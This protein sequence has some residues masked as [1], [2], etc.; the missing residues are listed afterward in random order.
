HATKF[1]LT[2]TPIVRSIAVRE[3]DNCVMTSLQSLPSSIIFKMP[4]ICPCTRF[5]R[6]L[7]FVP[8]STTQRLPYTHLV[9]LLYTP[10]GKSVND[11]AKMTGTFS[12]ISGHLSS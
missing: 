5:K 3:A 10:C 11:C 12:I 9:H 2:I 6:F 4:L 7:T 8:Y 1:S